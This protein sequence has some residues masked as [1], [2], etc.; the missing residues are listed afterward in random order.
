M[1]RLP[2]RIHG[3][4]SGRSWR[5]VTVTHASARRGRPMRRARTGDALF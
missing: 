1:V 4:L 2:P 3:G 5:V